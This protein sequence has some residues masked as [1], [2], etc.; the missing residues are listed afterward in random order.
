[1]S[2]SYKGLFISNVSLR[3][4][5]NGE[6]LRFSGSVPISSGFTRQT[7]SL[8]RGELILE[9]AAVIN[10]RELGRLLSVSAEYRLTASGSQTLELI[11][12]LA[13][14]CEKGFVILNMI[15]KTAAY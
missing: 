3:V 4:T 10:E 7:R 12:V 9:L 13:A 2:F 11:P 8:S 14:E 6:Y 15:D 1:V 5:R